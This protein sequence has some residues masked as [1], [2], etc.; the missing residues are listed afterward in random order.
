MYLRTVSIAAGMAALVS[1][2]ALA[3][4]QDAKTPL[5]PAQ[6]AEARGKIK[7]ASGLITLGRAE[8]DPMMLAVALKMLGG[9]EAPVD[10]P[11][12][13]KPYDLGALAE[14]AKGMAGDDKMVMEKISMTPVPKL[15]TDRYCAW[16]YECMGSGTFECGWDYSCGY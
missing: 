15:G 14:E 16:D 12:S 13:G 10:D 4:A 6:L 8:K 7:I 11:A 1:F 3:Q 5:S 2:T 9:L